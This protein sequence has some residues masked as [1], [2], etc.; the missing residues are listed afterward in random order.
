M[1]DYDGEIKLGV[2]LSTKDVVQQAKQLQTAI[3]QIFDAS[4]GK[5]L[6]AKFK[7]LLTRMDTVNSKA[8]KLRQQLEDLDSGK[9]KTKELESLEKQ[10]TQYEAL[11][12]SARKRGDDTAAEYY[13]SQ[14]QSILDQIENYDV[15]KSAEYQ[16]AETALAQLNNQMRI[17]LDQSQALS[18]ES[19]M[20]DVEQGAEQSSGA[21]QRLGET[22]RNAFSGAMSAVSAFAGR[23]RDAVVSMG[24]QMGST[25]AGFASKAI[26]PLTNITSKLLGIG[27][28][29]DSSGVSVKRL[30]KN[31]LRYGLGIR[32][33]FVLFN[34]VR[35][36]IKEGFNNLK[37]FNG[38]SN[39][40]ATTM[41]SLSASLT[42]LKNSWAAAFAPILQFVAPILQTLINILIS[43][44][45]AIGQFF[46]ALGGQ[47]KV[48]RAT[49]AQQGLGK[50]I[51]GTG[52]AADKAKG[53]LAAFDELNLLDQSGGG[54]GGG[55]G[56]GA[57]AGAGFEVVDVE[58]QFQDLAELFKQSWANAD[59]TEIGT[60]VGEAIKNGLDIAYDY[61]TGPIKD[62][63]WRLSRS[64][65][66][67]LNGVI[68]VPELGTSIGKVVGAGINDA[69]IFVVTFIKEFHWES[70]GALIT[71]AL[72]SALRE[73]DWS[74][75]T[76]FF[77]EKFKA[78][79]RFIR[80]AI[81]GIDWKAL[82]VDIWNAIGEALQGIDVDAFFGELGNL[83]GAAVRAAFDFGSVIIDALSTAW[84]GVKEYF[85]TWIKDTKEAG[86]NVVEGIWLGIDNAIANAGMWIWNHVCKPIYD[87]FVEFFRIGSPSKLMEEAGVFLIEG[88]YNGIVSLIDTI[89][90]IWEDLKKATI[91]I[92]TGL[93]NR[94]KEVWNGIKTSV[95]TVVTGIKTNVSNIWNGL[96]TSV[97]ATVT[98]LRDNVVNIFNTLKSKLDTVGSNIRNGL[99]TAFN[100]VKTTV[101]SIFNGMK[102]T[103]VNIFSGMWNGIRGWINRIIGGVEMMANG[104]VGGVNAV[105]RSLNKLSFKVPDWVPEIG[106]NRFGINIGLLGGVHLPRLAEGAVI[107]PNREFLAVLGDQSSGTNVE[108]PLDTIKAAV[109]D[110]LNENSG[111]DV[112]ELLR[113][114][115]TVVQS[116][117]LSISS[118]AIGDTAIEEI[119]SRT[120][121]TGNTPILG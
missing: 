22:I 59:F 2:K 66:T 76:G 64:L 90:K 13:N 72:Q 54:G 94:L 119:N 48:I 57:G 43:A 78:V 105:I 47:G 112:A 51:G 82:P 7:S 31:I 41:N 109:R 73:I 52:A 63:A 100:A 95:S 1:A 116:K 38:G 88:L 46:A 4:S 21:M 26:S 58:S 50:A 62:F 68:E 28:A 81:V 84:K 120:R 29:S 12:D 83:I 71:E 77:V 30:F 74:L 33:V 114:L 110:V 115:I 14:A 39:S 10:M 49:K 93:G 113:E 8:E 70:L 25:I 27:R 69:L 98:G 65:A 24:Q 6:D 118:K 20:D 23:A 79:F 87:G 99:S 16:K 37:E 9:T 121:R 106:G 36:G 97:S 35:N 34:K 19:P 32:S 42:T 89:K 111:G 18:G 5:Q 85:N 56:G 11:A 40:V 92:I 101:S 61:L 96:K 75:V 3:Q 53:Q 15:T 17:L 107:P 91:D 86:G 45:N 80:G 108:A 117:N 103:V 55:G 104:F 44:A 60:M 67:F 102:N